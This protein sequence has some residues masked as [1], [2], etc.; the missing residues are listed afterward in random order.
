MKNLPFLI[1]ALLLLAACGETKQ[2]AGALAKKTAAIVT[3]D[4]TLTDSSRNRPIPVAFYYLPPENNIPCKGF[5]LISHGYNA[6]QG[7]PYKGY[8][9]IAN[10]LAAEGYWVTSIQHELPADEPIAM[11]GVLQQTR[12]PNWQRGVQNIYFVLQYLKNKYPNV[13][14]KNT[15]LIGHSNGGDMS[16]LFAHLH[17]QLVSK[18]ISLD[19]R[20]MPFPRVTEPRLYS[21]RSGDQVA[22][23]GVLPNAEEQQRLN[24]RIVQLGNTK[25]GE[26]GDNATAAQQKE[27]LNYILKFAAD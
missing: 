17:P 26:M 13:N 14:A 11:T 20:R 3:A 1:A 25:H 21:L 5:V 19:N 12:R 27:L 16:V 2:T 10:A 7:T 15:I 23:A 22:D 8:S 4:T 18:V 6:N 9:F 24:M